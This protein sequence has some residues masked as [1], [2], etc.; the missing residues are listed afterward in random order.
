MDIGAAEM[1]CQL[2]PW[3]I[4]AAAYSLGGVQIGHA[5]VQLIEEN[6]SVTYLHLASCADQGAAGAGA[7]YRSAHGVSF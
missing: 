3:P 5:Y 1:T 6:W 4:G 2:I 7:L